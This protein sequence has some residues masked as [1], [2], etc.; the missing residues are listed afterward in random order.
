MVPSAVCLA[1]FW[2]GLLAW[3][4]RDDF[5]WLGL[6]LEVQDRAGFW[7]AMFEPMAQGTIRP[8][9]ERGFFM[10]FSALFGLDA[11]PY[12][13]AVFLT[14]F[15]ALFLLSRVAWRLSGG[16]WLAAFLAPLFWGINSALS[17]PLS[18]TS[19]YN[20]VMCAAF[21]LGG[22]LLW[23]RF[24]ETGRRRY[25]WS[26]WAV[27]LLGFGV[28][29][30]NI[31]Y[32]G[33]VLAWTVLAGRTRR[34]LGYAAAMAPVSAGYFLLHNRLAPKQ[35]SGL[36]ALHLDTSMI[37]TLGRYWHDAFGSQGIEN[38]EMPAWLVSLGGA[39]PWLLTLA[40]AAFA[41][42]TLWQRQWLGLFG[43]AW[44]L[45]T[46]APV[47]PLRDHY[48][49]YYLA[50]PTIGVAIAGAE[51]VALGWQQRRLLGLASLVLAAIYA[52]TTIPV[53]RGGA[54]YYR[55]RSQEAERLVF[56]VQRA[57]EL[58]PNKVIL[59][60]DVSPDLFWFAINDR[61]L[62][63]LGISNVFLA[64]GAEESIPKNPELGDIDA[65][66]FPSGQVSR[67]LEREEAV[68]YSTNGGR[69][70]NVTKVYKAVAAMRWKPTLAKRVD[71]GNSVFAD[72]VLEG[73][74]KND[75]GFRWM[76][77]RGAVR[78]GGPGAWVVVSGYA[79]KEI[80]D[81][82]PVHLT[83]SAN[84]K[85]AGTPCEIN[86]PNAPFTCRFDLPASERSKEVIH[87]V[88]LLDKV[89]VQPGEDRELGVILG[90]VG[91]E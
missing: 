65:F 79:A 45:A 3:F 85:P 55:D 20:Q 89:L 2:P 48:S 28:L 33:I 15:L 86:Q 24:A 60:T 62:R 66:L 12:R 56:G 57:R 52:T 39:S 77:R 8:W 26:Q 21:L 11:L 61:P 47:L 84:E 51:A 34:L 37:S 14:Q 67:V 53:S 59:L 82:G 90:T 32:P 25:Y 35:K 29:E 43:F 18:W 73:W 87:V 78:L 19:A 1:V 40:L 27:F 10:L 75:G 4:H 23:L 16:R 64:P 70:R 88:L 13:I 50:I 68:V 63:L 58:H 54:S 17:T 7:R 38:F 42:A 44:F 41:A 30:I 6:R 22:F 5:A 83:V 76:S 91:I 80:L 9:S 74:H 81:R 49:E 31:V 46:I 36:Y 71:V 69:L 72:Q